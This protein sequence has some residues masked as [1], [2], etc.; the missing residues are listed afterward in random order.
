M[1]LYQKYGD[2]KMIQIK[3]IAATGKWKAT[4]FDKVLGENYSNVLVATYKVYKYLKGQ[5]YGK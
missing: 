1:I 5:G 2:S 4:V 3:Q